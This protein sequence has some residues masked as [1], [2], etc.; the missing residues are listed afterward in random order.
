MTQY[1]ML[2]VKSSNSQLKKLKRTIRN[3]TEVTLNLSS[4]L[5]GNSNDETNFPQKLLLTNTQVS[6][7]CKSVANG[8]SANTKFSKTHLSKMMQSGGILGDLLVPLQYAAIK[9]G[10]QEL[11]KTA[12]ELTKHATN[13]S[14]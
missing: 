11:I 13:L 2:K 10:T 7:I 4:N 1:N 14:C 9:G 8:S 6:K 12:P 5:G 3:G